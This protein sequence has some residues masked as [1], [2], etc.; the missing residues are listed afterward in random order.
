MN[1]PQTMNSNN[2]IST[3]SLLAKLIKQ[4]A[5]NSDIEVM[6]LYGSRAKGSTQAHSDFDLAIAFKNFNLSSTEKFLRPNE[7]AL[8]WNHENTIPE[9]TISIVDIN[10]APLYLA[11]NIIDSGQV[12][13]QVESS[14]LYHE[15]NRISNQYEHQIIESK[16]SDQ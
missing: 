16:I 2:E 11:H 8:D 4:A 15:Q 10:L 5:N 3:E 14:R 9:D 13:Y 6:W 12:I 1:K 7:L